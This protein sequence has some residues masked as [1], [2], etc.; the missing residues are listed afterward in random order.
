L[1]TGK[2]PA[3][4]MTERPIGVMGTGSNM[5]RSGLVHSSGTI[6]LG[7]YGPQPALLWAYDPASGE[8]AR[9]GAPGEYQ[10]DS[11][12]EA[13]NGK[14]YIGTAYNALV[15]ELDPVSRAIRCLGTPPLDSTSWI[16]AMTRTRDGAIYG[17]KGVGL[18]RLDWETGRLHSC[19]LVPGHHHTLGPNPGGA[20]IR[21]L[22]ER[23]DGLL[24]GDTNRW[25]FTFDPRSGK[26]TP[27][28]DMVTHDE[29]IFCIMHNQE[30]GPT[31]DLYL[32]LYSRFGGRAVERPFWVCRAET[33]AVESLDIQGLRHPIPFDA[34]GWWHKDGRSHWMVVCRDGDTDASSVA[35]ID[36]ERRRVAETWEIEDGEMPPVRL[37]GSGDGLWFMSSARGTLY[38]ADPDAGRLVPVAHN[39]E[40][41][42]CRCLAASP[43]NALGTDSYDCGYAFTRDLRTGMW[44]HHGRVWFDDHRA[45]YGPAA[46]AGQDGRYL[47][48]NHSEALSSLWVT[49]TAT[50]RHW[51]VGDAALQLVAC[52]DGSVWGT[53]G[54]N[55]SAYRFDAERCWIP[56]WQGRPGPLFQYRPGAKGVD[57]HG[58]VGPVGP[59]CATSEPGVLC[60]GRGNE[61]IWYDSRTRAV[62]AASDLPAPAQQAVGDP[63]GGVAYLLL[64]D[65]H[66]L[67]CT[68]TKADGATIEP[69]AAGFG[70]ARGLFLLSASRR[71]VGVAQDGTVSVYDPHTGHVSRA[72]GPPPPPAGPAVDA[73]EDAWYYAH[74]AVTRFALEERSG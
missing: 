10:L 68:G 72:E 43:R 46:F 9:I 65:G 61:V 16:F 71:V 35:L 42:E 48:A 5:F 32:T 55:P 12:V 69:L 29:G 59:L 11:M 52:G 57:P 15:Y 67:R 37:P 40:P 64:S 21:T 66:L 17:A 51:R 74:R 20:I 33:G 27:V 14:V 62:V 49:D 54:R 18:F 53:S 26:I 8:L 36:V 39:P 41:V 70:A 25:I 30:V 24:W 28:A 13:P 6:F 22:A 23:P 56:A 47:L 2:E 1:H 7:T 19:G 38:R 4:R 73:V 3:L 45:N 31:G 44:Q 63:A 58:E 60:I 34:A 50:R